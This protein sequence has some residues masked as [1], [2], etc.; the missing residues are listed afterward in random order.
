M[1]LYYL[2]ICLLHQVVSSDIAPEPLVKLQSNHRVPIQSISFLKSPSHVAIHQPGLPVELLSIDKRNTLVPVVLNA[3]IS[4]FVALSPN[5][6]ICAFYKENQIK[7]WNMSSNTLEKSITLPNT[8]VPTIMALS[9]DSKLLAVAVEAPDPLYRQA[10]DEVKALT[11]FRIYIISTESGK[12]ITNVMGYLAPVR[13]MVFSNKGNLLAGG[14]A[15]TIG[16]AGVVF[17]WNI[18]T[19]QQLAELKEHNEMCSSV[20]FSPDDSTL[21]T[22]SGFKGSG[23]V[24]LWDTRTWKR[25][26]ELEGHFKG[27]L[28]L[29]FSPDGNLLASGGDE[30]ILW[31]MKSG[32]NVTRRGSKVVLKDPLDDQYRVAHEAVKFSVQSLAFSN[33]SKTIAAGG[34]NGDAL[35]WNVK[36]LL[37]LN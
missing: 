28:C 27:V 14:T 17:V 18:S 22:A 30:I 35:L 1:L 25:V 15:P 24:Q 26:R 2:S 12:I 21:G 13:S 3:T 5:D 33:D 6:Q 8:I 34:T 32:Q 4:S 23:S 10:Q 19:G 29:A 7:L 36:D 9:T 11:S 31:S 37:D 20:A 16:N